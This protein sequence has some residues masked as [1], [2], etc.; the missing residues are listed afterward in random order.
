MEAYVKVNTD[1]SLL[2][3]DQGGHASARTLLLRQRGHLR[4]HH[5]PA[6]DLHI[7]QVHLTEEPSALCGTTLHKQALKRVFDGLECGQVVGHEIEEDEK[8]FISL[9]RASKRI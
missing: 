7:L 9:R 2:D 8:P 6:P 3:S 5:S 4:L 1:Q